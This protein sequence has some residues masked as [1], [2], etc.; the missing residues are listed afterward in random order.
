MSTF[1]M[2][3]DHIYA[4]D[5]SI[6]FKTFSAGHLI[7]LA[8]IAV[9]CFLSGLIYKKLSGH[10]RDQMRKFCA[11][12]VVILEYAKIIVMGLFEVNILEFVPLHLCSATGLAV[13]IY[14]LWPGKKWLGQMFAFAFVPAA[15]LAVIFPSTTMYPWWNFYCLHTFIFHALLIAFFVWLFMAGEI[16]PD[17]KGVWTGLGLM[18]AFAVPI[19]FLDGAFNVNYMFIGMRSDV[20]I[21][22]ALWDFFVPKFGRAVFAL[23]IS[24]IMIVV[25]HVFFGIYKLLLLGRKK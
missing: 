9:F 15:L 17:Y 2:H 21:L 20:G 18:A 16:V 24:A 7:W 10:G 25:A 14:A 12:A 1:W 6:G 23:V 8:A 3:R 5:L 13:V 19:Y 4:Q 11:L 22:A